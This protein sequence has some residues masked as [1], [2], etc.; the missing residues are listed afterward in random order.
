MAELHLEDKQLVKDQLTTCLVETLVFDDR[1]IQH[2]IRTAVCGRRIRYRGHLDKQFPV[3]LIVNAV[4]GED[5]SGVF[6]QSGPMTNTLGRP[7]ILTS[8]LTKFAETCSGIGCLGM[9]LEQA[10]FN[11]LLKNDVN[12]T[13]LNLAKRIDETPLLQGD[14]GSS[15][16]IVDVCRLC[17]EPINLAAGVSCQPHSRLGDRKGGNDPRAETLPSTLKLGFYLRAPVIILECVEDIKTS[18][19]AQDILKQFC[20]QTGYKLTQDTL[21][22]QDV[23]PTRRSRWWAILAH[24][25]IGSIP[26]VPFPKV[27][28]MPMVLHLLNEFKEW[29][30]SDTEQLLLDTYELNAFHHQGISNNMVPRNGQAPNCLHS[31]GNQMMACPCGCRNTQFS[32]HRIDKGGLHGMLIQQPGTTKTYMGNLQNMRHIH[33]SE[34]ALLNGLK[35]SLNLGSNLRLALCAVGQLASPIQAAWIGAHVMEHFANKGLVQNEI[36]P[37]ETL[38]RAMQSLLQQRDQ[39]FGKPNN[40][41]T[42]KFTKMVMQKTFVMPN[43]LMVEKDPPNQIDQG[44][45]IKQDEGTEVRGRNPQGPPRENT[46]TGKGVGQSQEAKSSDASC[47]HPKVASVAAVVQSYQLPGSEHPSVALGHPSVAPENNPDMN[48]IGMGR[49]VHEPQRINGSTKNAPNNAQEEADFDNA[50]LAHLNPAGN[51]DP[52]HSF[53]NIASAPSQP[54]PDKA[55][56]VMGFENKRL[57]QD[58]HHSLGFVSSPIHADEPKGDESK[59]K[60]SK[61]QQGQE[62]MEI[63]VPKEQHYPQHKEDNKEIQDTHAQEHD[64]PTPSSDIHIGVMTPQSTI[65]LVIKTT[66]Q[67]PA[68]QL[69][70]AEAQIGEWKIPIT[71]RN[72]VGTV[73]YDQQIL[74][75]GQVITIH[76]PSTAADIEC[77]RRKQ[78]F[79]CPTFS[80]PCTRIEALHQQK[81]WVAVDEMNYY[82]SHIAEYQNI[83]SIP[84]NHFLTKG[85]AIEHGTLWL[86]QIL[87]HQ[88]NTGKHI[89]TAAI[90]DHHWVPFYLHKDDCSTIAVTILDGNDLLDK[91]TDTR[92][93]KVHIK[94]QPVVFSADCG[95]Q[96]FA[97]LAGTA[98]GNWDFNQAEAMTP[99]Q[100]ELWRH[101]FMHELFNKQ[102]TAQTITDLPVGGMKSENEI[103]IKLSELLKTHGVWEDRLEERVQGVIDRL[104]FHS[105]KSILVAPR[106]WQDLKSAANQLSPPMQLIRSDELSAQIASR[107][108]TTRH[109]GKIKT[110]ITKPRGSQQVLNIQAKDLSIPDGVF[111]QEDGKILSHL[112]SQ[113]IGP[114]SCGITILDQIDAEPILR[115]S[116]PVSNQGLGVMVLATSSNGAEHTTQPVRFPA[117]CNTSQEPVLVSGYLYQLGKQAVMRH[118]PVTKIAV[119]ETPVEAVRCLVYKDQANDIWDTMQKQ[120]VKAIFDSVPLLN[121]QGG[122]VKIVDVWDRQ[123]LTKRFEKAK[124]TASDIFVCSIRIEAE[125][126]EELLASSSTNGIYFEPRTQCGRHPSPNYHV[127]WLKQTNYQDAKYSQQTSPQSTTLVRYGDRYGLRSDT[128]NAGEIHQRFRPDTPL[129]LGQSRQVYLMGPLPFSTTREAVCKLLKA[130]GWD[131]RPLQAKGRSADGSGVTWAI[132]AVEEPGHYVYTLAHGDVLISKSSDNR[133]QQQDR[134]Y[135]IVA[136]KKTI[137]KLQSTDA[138]DPWTKQDPWGGYTP[139]STSTASS[140]RQQALTAGQIA[141]VEANIEQRI[142]ASLNNQGREEDTPMESVTTALEARVATLE[143]Q[144]QQVSAQQQ[145]TD[146]KIG[147]FQQQMDHHYNSLNVNIETKFNDQMNRLEALLSKR[148]FME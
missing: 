29:P 140:S 16:T 86:D 119:E 133:P 36:S 70:M 19:W 5:G 143:S 10:G 135:N 42:Q 34:L 121:P 117:I 25:A 141:T 130:W 148:K 46:K 115:L 101:L 14:V 39:I 118:E 23:W 77:P 113:Q 73:V 24:P 67:T 54:T 51:T 74:N 99:Q 93:I 100:A 13:I 106:P 92:G 61:Q 89:V 72:A 2:V 32:L 33:P 21:R 4:V 40:V 62:N 31:C 97:W 58:T 85:E 66:S 11:I 59:T 102:V 79:G 107:V 96:A 20:D 50:I 71:L 26:F 68:V 17:P 27:E 83:E 122:K 123:W 91:A 109:I 132:Q 12:Q 94:E 125:H 146:A 131:A 8:N 136:S 114:S 75:P 124:Q 126:L 112:Q 56:G 60:K 116:R 134:T 48:T 63:E 38:F 108:Q 43:P 55:G 9:G 105:L 6:L 78:H 138:P 18:C 65:P 90:I 104:S 137:T 87:D 82:L 1:Q 28:P 52:K 35:P 103:R 37:K 44:S 22:L 98:N 47:W 127:T 80:F 129:L 81:A 76:P 95:F 142:R 69:A 15:S 88:K 41:N 45:D 110:S 120:P 111:K 53:R 7:S 128:M 64:V 139:S 57:R 144:I 84:V 145:Q 30:Q 3:T 49:V 147:Q